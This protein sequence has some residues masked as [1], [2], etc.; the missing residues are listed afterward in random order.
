[1]QIITKG[2]G[3]RV[4]NE[5]SGAADARLAVAFY[6]PSQDV[7]DVLAALS[8]LSLVISEEFTINDPHKL[9]SLPKHFIIRSLPTQTQSGK[10][11]AKVLIVTRADNSLWALVGSANMTYQGLFANQEACVALDSND[12]DRQAIE[13]LETWFRTVLKDAHEPNYIL[14]KEIFDAR[15]EYRLERR[16]KTQTPANYYVLKTTSGSD[17]MEHWPEFESGN[18]IAIGWEGLKVDPSK[19]SDNQ[20]LDALK[21]SHP[22]GSP[23]Q[24]LKTIRRFIAMKEGDIALI[25]HGYASNQQKPVHIYGLARVTGPF[26]VEPY[27]QRL[28]RFKHDAVIQVV[29]SDFPMKALARALDSGSLMRALVDIDKAA[30]DRVATLLKQGGIQIDV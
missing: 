10:L 17:G 3:Q 29:R 11:H 30:F 13:N 14:A 1:M 12:G 2:I 21:E 4:L 9:E 25:C 19:R 26:R 16:P 28:W 27:N 7:Q 24:A 22:D 8:N 15:A 20:L 18:C 5:L 6:S 23:K